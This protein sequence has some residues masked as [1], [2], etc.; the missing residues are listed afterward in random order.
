MKATFSKIAWLLAITS[1]GGLAST[2]SAG[3]HYLGD[4]TFTKDCATLTL[5]ASGRIAGLGNANAIV[6]ISAAANPTTTCTSPGGNQ[7]P[8]QNPAPIILTGV[9]SVNNDAD[10]KNGS[11]SFMVTTDP[12]TQ[13][14]NA[15]TAGCPN[16]NWTA[17]IDNLDF[18]SAT[19]TVTQ[20][21]ATVLGPTTFPISPPLSACP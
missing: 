3:V 15:K 14:T 7:S 6:S 9:A 16:K 8:G 13:P 18:T 17:H 4:V 12:P 10:P 19:I 11:R 2:A 21:T 1:L 5:T 20:G